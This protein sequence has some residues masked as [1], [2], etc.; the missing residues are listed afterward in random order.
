[1]IKITNTKILSTIPP[2]SQSDQI[3]QKLI[4]PP[5]NL[6]PLNFSHPTHQQ[7]KPTIH[8]IPKLPKPLNKTIPLLFHTKPPQIPTHNIKHPLIL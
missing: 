1:M 8:T 3:L 5:I 6:P 4:N 7:H 2:P